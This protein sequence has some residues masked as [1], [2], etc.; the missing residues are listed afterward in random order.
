MITGPIHWELVFRSQAAYNQLFVLGTALARD[1]SCGFTSWGHS[2]AV[3][4]WGKVIAEAGVGEEAVFSDIDLA[5]V[6]DVRRQLPVFSQRR[7]DIY[8][9]K[10][11]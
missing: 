7:E 5:M 1:P 3:D 8:E 11:R 4:P 6:A 2:L 10:L 9:L